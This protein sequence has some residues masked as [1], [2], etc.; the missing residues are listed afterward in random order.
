MS[1]RSFVRAVALLLLATRGL[2]AQAPAES[3]IVRDAKTGAPLRCLHVMLVDSTDHAVAHTVTDSAGTFVIVA[4]ATGIYRVGFE[5]F[6]WERLVGPA[7]TLHDGELRE[8]AYP[9]TFAVALHGDSLAPGGDLIAALRRRENDA[10]HSASVQTPD[11]AIR[12]PRRMALL[13]ASGDVVAQYVVD[14]RGRVPGDSWRPL[15]FTNDDFLTALRAHL[16]TM[17]YAPARLAGRPVCELVRN[18][19]AFDWRSP[20]PM[21]TVFN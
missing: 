13:R 14:E 5:I 20:L 2:V 21:V 4:P 1:T 15:T 8:R 16:P 19:V 12:Y 18:R 10:W 17:R 6:G 11:V 7:D 9:L 3:G